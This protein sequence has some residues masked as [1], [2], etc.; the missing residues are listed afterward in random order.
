MLWGYK[1]KKGELYVIQGE[2]MG[3]L[4]RKEKRIIANGLIHSSSE[5]W[6]SSKEPAV[7]IS[8]GDKACAVQKH[9]RACATREENSFKTKLA[10]IILPRISIGPS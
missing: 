6:G 8:C 3:G 7:P 4:G 10:P 9:L 5:C 1:R 2:G